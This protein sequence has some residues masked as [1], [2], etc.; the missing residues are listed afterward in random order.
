MEQCFSINSYNFDYKRTNRADDIADET[1]LYLATISFHQ[2]ANFCEKIGAKLMAVPI[3]CSEALQLI[4]H[5]N[6]NYY[7]IPYMVNFLD[8]GTDGEHPGPKQ[9]QWYADQIS[10]IIKKWV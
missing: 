5:N 1:R 7:Q 3:L 4:L 9:H 6:P 8:M 10:K 2:V